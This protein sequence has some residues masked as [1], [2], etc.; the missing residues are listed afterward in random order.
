M[1]N[2]TIVSILT[3]A[4]LTSAGCSSTTVDP[5]QPTHAASPTASGPTASPTPSPT[6]PAPTGPMSVAQAADYYLDW[7][8]WSNR[9]GGWISRNLAGKTY[10]Q[11]LNGSLRA[12]VR[13]AAKITRD[14]AL[15]LD[16]PPQPWPDDVLKPMNG[17]VD[18]LLQQVSAFNLLASATT[19]FG[20]SHAWDEYLKADFVT[21]QKVRLRLGLP[22]ATSKKDGCAGRGS[23]PRLLVSPSASP[24]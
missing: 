6:T 13:R 1:W 12:K 16:A 4:S 23:D 24:S 18:S 7:V 2:V 21:A 15:A 19:A 5:A 22:S 9:A 11:T 20:R 3:A 10:S 14:T 8:C 17:V